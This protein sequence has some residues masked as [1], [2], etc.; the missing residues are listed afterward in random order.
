MVIVCLSIT[1]R[2]DALPE[3]SKLVGK[4]TRWI[5]IYSRVLCGAV[6]DKLTPGH[7]I[8]KCPGVE[9]EETFTDE[10]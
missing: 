7:C 5:Q 8:A 2:C 1:L 10:S 9:A 6:D 3:I 4:A